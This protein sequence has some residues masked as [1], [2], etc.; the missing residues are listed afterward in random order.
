[1][2]IGFYIY[3]DLRLL[4]IR[5]H[6]VITQTERVDT[7]LAWLRDPDYQDCIDAILDVTAAQ[8]VPKLAELRQIMAILRQHMPSRGPKKL[9]IV[10][11]RPITYAVARVFQGLIQPK[12]IPLQ[13]RV[14]I[15]REVAWAWLRPGQPR[16][17]SR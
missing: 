7:I 8:S 11:A 16:P 5:G 15:D 13:V 9:A 17:E 4:F 3:R 6:G 14:F 10:T 2:P 12:D 1:M